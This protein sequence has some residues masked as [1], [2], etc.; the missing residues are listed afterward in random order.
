MIILRDISLVKRNGAYEIDQAGQKVA[1]EP[2]GIIILR[3]IFLTNS[4]RFSVFR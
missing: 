4:P 3:I 1:A 2:R